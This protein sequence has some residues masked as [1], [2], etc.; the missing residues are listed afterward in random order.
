MKLKVDTECGLEN[1]LEVVPESIA[2]RQRRIQRD[3]RA[4]E[5]NG[6]KMGLL[7]LLLKLTFIGELEA[8]EEP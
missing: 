2:A 4:T 1:P 7:R 3:P 5:S 8:T 6:V